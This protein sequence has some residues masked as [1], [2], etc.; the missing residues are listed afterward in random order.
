MTKKLN[1]IKSID[2]FKIQKYFDAT[3]NLHPERNLRK[4]IACN[5]QM[6]YLLSMED[7]HQADSKY[8]LSKGLLG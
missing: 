5:Q 7:G 2:T 3:I 6:A 4:L 1:L 8:H